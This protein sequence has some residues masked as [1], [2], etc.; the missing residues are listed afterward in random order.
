[1]I[2]PISNLEQLIRCKLRCIGGYHEGSD[3]GSLQWE[4]GGTEFVKDY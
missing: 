1:M 4:D 2:E 3:G